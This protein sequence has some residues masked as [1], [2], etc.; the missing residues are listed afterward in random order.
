MVKYDKQFKLKVVKQYIPNR[1]G[2][3][4]VAQAHELTPSMVGRWIAAYRSHGQAALVKKSSSYTSKF[5][6]S[7]LRRMWR[8]ELSYSQTAALFD[9]RG[10]GTIQRWEREY[11]AGGVDALVPKRGRYKVRQKPPKPPKPIA[12]K[13]DQARSRE[14]LLEEVEYLRTEVA[15]LKKW[16]ALIQ[17]K[18]AAAPK[19]RR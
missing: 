4:A 8:N 11:H 2:V 18:Q 10:V 12:T 14:E 16:D 5:K 19:K 15:F 1:H 7:V 6:L 17:A 13:A 3:T 9:I